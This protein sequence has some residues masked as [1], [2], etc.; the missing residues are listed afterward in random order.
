MLDWIKRLGIA[1]C[2]DQR[3]GLSDRALAL[4]REDFAVLNDLSA[5]V[6]ECWNDLRQI[7]GE[8]PGFD[9]DWEKNTQM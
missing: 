2:Y 4:L 7:A 8:G 1:K 6:A 3:V 5:G 9:P